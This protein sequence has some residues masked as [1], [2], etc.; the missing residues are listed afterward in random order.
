[1]SIKIVIIHDDLP[2][3]DPLIDELSDRYKAENVILIKESQKGLD[4]VLNNLTQK[5]IVI[6]DLKFKANEIS[7]VKVFE[8][9]RKQTS[10]VYII[11]WTANNLNEVS[12]QDLVKFIN[13]DALAF[14]SSTDDYTKVLEQV[15]KA[16]HELDSR[17]ASV[18]E[19]WISA[20]PSE[21]KDKPYITSSD[22]KSY[23]LSELLQEIR[24]QTSFGKEIEKNILLLAIDLLTRGKEKLS[25]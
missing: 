20:R 18:I 1:M 19:Q 17:V 22:G 15:E 9:I 8:N 16:A 4:Y 23:T 6:L 21:E 12:S 3:D 14:I 11:I 7:G 2:E 10:L 13:N 5:I 24:H 25:G